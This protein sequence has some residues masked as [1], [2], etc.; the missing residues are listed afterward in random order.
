MPRLGNFT[1]LWLRPQTESNSNGTLAL[2]KICGSCIKVRVG[3]CELSCNEERLCLHMLLLP[4]DYR[5][6]VTASAFTVFLELSEE[7][8]QMH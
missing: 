2:K 1:F 6:I 4:K 8:P 3:C 7:R 5:F